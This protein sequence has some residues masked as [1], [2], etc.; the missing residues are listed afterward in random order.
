[1]LLYLENNTGMQNSKSSAATSTG[2][3]E[4]LYLAGRNTEWNGL[5]RQAF[6]DVLTNSKMTSV[7]TLGITS[8]DPSLR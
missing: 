3:T 1:M 7:F 5:Y 2:S 8:R 6:D 4:R